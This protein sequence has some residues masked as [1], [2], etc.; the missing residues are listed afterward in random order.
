MNNMNRKIIFEVGANN[1]RD[2]ENFASDPNSM[3]YAFEPS[4]ILVKELYDKFGTRENVK[5]FPFAVGLNDRTWEKFNVCDFG[6]RGLGSLYDWHENLLNTVLNK[7]AEFKTSFPENKTEVYMRRLDSIMNEF[8]IDSI[9]WLHI[10]AQGSD[11]NVIK[12]L[13]ERIKD[14]KGGRCECTLEIP[15]YTN[16][17]NNLH[18][19]VSKFLTD[20]GFFVTVDYI[21][22][23]DSEVDLKFERRE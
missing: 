22:A 10:D 1:G 3:V 13:G 17:P 2:T 21:H 19:D 12:S 6:D 5:I 4:P 7:H 14:V 23:D 20:A 15:L 11:F 9:D 8:M 18:T 16:S